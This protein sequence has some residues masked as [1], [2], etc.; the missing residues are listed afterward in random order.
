VACAG[1]PRYDAKDVVAS[2]RRAGAARTKTPERLA[3][4][5]H[6]I[7]GIHGI[8]HLAFMAFMAFFIW[9]SWH[10]WHSWHFA[11]GIEH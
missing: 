1:Q 4:G 7:H 5:I 2:S 10:S 6:G 8:L 9:H 3:F 11:F